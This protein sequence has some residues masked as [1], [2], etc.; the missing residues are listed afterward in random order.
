MTDSELDQDVG[1]ATL[2]VYD[3]YNDSV[4]SR[5]PEWSEDV[6][7]YRGTYLG[8]VP[9]VP[10]SDADTAFLSEEID[11]HSG[12]ISIYADVDEPIWL[13]VHTNDSY[14]DPD[15]WDKP[16]EYGLVYGPDIKEIGGG[17]GCEIWGRVVMWV[18]ERERG[19][20]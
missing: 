5:E 19:D 20:R 10:P 2:E 6:E 18:A 15:D 13:F 14:H 9:N 11:Y 12:P 16:V 1:T 3:G 17:F 7:I 4:P 8:S